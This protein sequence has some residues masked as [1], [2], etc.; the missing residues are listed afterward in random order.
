MKKGKNKL[1]SSQSQLLMALPESIVE[2]DSILSTG[3]H[4]HDAVN[5][6]NPLHSWILES[7]QI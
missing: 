6:P 7:N 1:S 3:N 5:L 2:R 4:G